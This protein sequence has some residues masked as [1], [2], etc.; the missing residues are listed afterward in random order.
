MDIVIPKEYFAGLRV[1]GVKYTAFFLKL[2]LNVEGRSRG[3]WLIRSSP[4]RAGWVGALLEAS[5]CVLGQD[6]LLS[7]CLSPRRG[8]NG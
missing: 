1:T 4:D 2:N 8:V 7:Q 6:T 3:S 5:C